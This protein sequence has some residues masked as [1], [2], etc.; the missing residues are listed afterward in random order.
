MRF[1]IQQ[2]GA[3]RSFVAGALLIGGTLLP[4]GVALL[5]RAGAQT[6]PPAAGVRSAIPQEA[7][8]QQP[9]TRKLLDGVVGVIGDRVILSSAIER[10]VEAGT[11]GRELSP[12]ERK[13][14][15]E[16]VLRAMAR[17]EI[18]V[19]I[20]KVIGRDDPAMFE[21]QIRMLL[22]EYKREQVERYGSFT[23]MSE[24]LEA[25]GLTW[26]TL[27]DEQRNRILGDTARQSALGQRFRDGVQLLVTPREMFDFYRDNPD[28]FAARLV[29][30]LAWI[31]FPK[32]EPDA[33][34]Q[35]AGAAAAWKGS[36]DADRD[37]AA[38]FGG[39]AMRP[40][41]GVRPIDDDPRAPFLKD[42]AREGAEGDVLGPLDRGSSL[43]VVRVLR[44]I[45]QPAL[46]FEDA[47]VQ[48]AIR[49]SLIE[50]RIRGLESQVLAYKARQI[51][52]I[53][54][55]ILGSR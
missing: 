28:E 46:R 32:S 7:S 30:D 1:G 2:T 20:G 51:M 38:R 55:W 21:G 6:T 24:E 42:F 47:G 19:Q 10:E 41:L 35:A 25:L 48:T 3:A 31:S 27:E 40:A 22:E 23:R 39:I 49:R 8:A 43:F 44:K 9:T 29:A 34:E 36:N 54:P 4:P 13:R 50:R 5:P 45:D 18:W 11:A 15:E 16:E 53:P 12:D 37:I 26:Q 33:A 17:E 52:R 14:A